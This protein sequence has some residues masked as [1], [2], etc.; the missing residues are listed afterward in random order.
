MKAKKVFRPLNVIATEIRAD[1]KQVYFGAVPYL[2]A[3][4]SLDNVNDSYGMD[5]AKSIVAYFLSNA[6]TWRGEVA[7]NI[8]KELNTMIK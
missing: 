5:N 7:R 4:R 3:M 8:K 1:W 6:G 2:A